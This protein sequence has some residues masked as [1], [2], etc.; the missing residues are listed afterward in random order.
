MDKNMTLYGKYR[1]KDLTITNYDLPNMP[2]EAELKNL[3]WLAKV[4]TDLENDIG[5]FTIISAFRS[6]QVQNAVLG[7]SPTAQVNRNKSFHE[8]GMAV[9]LWPTTQTIEA[10]FG[11]ILASDYWPENLGEISIKPSQNAI[12]LSLPTTRLKNKPMILE[13]GSY[14]KLT[15]NEIEEYR[16][17]YMQYYTPVNRQPVTQDPMTP[18]QSDE[19]LDFDWEHI[20]KEDQSY[21]LD[22]NDSLFNF[23]TDFMDDFSLDTTEKKV[24]LGIG[25]FAVLGLSAWMLL[26]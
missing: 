25:I 7:H 6:Y 23:N 15:Q 4:L 3:K 1:L 20:M 24:G 17:P 16:K 19:A 14:R 18:I 9:D 10:F 8:A 2:N 26:R 13:G 21:L 5:P 11:K 22:S 12:H